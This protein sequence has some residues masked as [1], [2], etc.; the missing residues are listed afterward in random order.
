MTNFNKKKNLYFIL[1]IITSIVS[2]LSIL[3]VAFSPLGNFKFLI[4]LILAI[5]FFFTISHVKYRLDFYIFKEQHYN[6]INGVEKPYKTK[7]PIL[8]KVWI[9]RLNDLNYTTYVIDND[10]SFYYKIEQLEEKRKTSKTLTLL[11][12]LHDNKLSFDS[13]KVI[14]KINDLE[15][16]LRKK[17]KYRQRVFIH[18]KSYNTLNNERLELANDVFWIKQKNEHIT[19]INVFYFK[20]DKSVY[21]LHNKK[22]Y[23]TRF[24]EYAVNEI[25]K[26]V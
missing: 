10:I 15:L 2:V 21:F 19:S 14:N 13:P 6:L 1:T 9:D 26:I 17:E 24:Y 11:I 5:I 25:I 4:V 23:P 8:E 18:F 7:L 20:Q 22:Y 16:K 3:I 12:L